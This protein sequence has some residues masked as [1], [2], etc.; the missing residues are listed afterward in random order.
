MSRFSLLA[1]LPPDTSCKGAPTK[2]LHLVKREGHLLAFSVNTPDVGE[3][4]APGDTPLTLT[5]QTVHMASSEYGNHSSTAVST[6][7]GLWTPDLDC[8]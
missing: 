1:V 3:L 2:L 6:V 8:L 7:P 4:V 5:I